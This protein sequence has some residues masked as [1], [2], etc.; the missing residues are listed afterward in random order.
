MSQKLFYVLEIIK[1][2]SEPI[3]AKEIQGKLAELGIIINIKTVYQLIKKA[4]EYYEHVL[5]REY[6]QTIRKKGYIINEDYFNDGQLQYL[7]DSIVFNKN[8]STKEIEDI[9][10][11]LLFYSSSNQINRINIP[12]ISKTNQPFSLLLNLTTL[13]RAINNQDL[14]Y[15]KYV[16]YKVNSDKL[17][18]VSSANGNLKIGEDI[19]YEVSP[20]QI[21]LNGSNYYLLG[22]FNKRKDQLSMYRV[23]RMRMIRKSN[24][25]FIDIREQFDINKEISNNVNM[26]ISTKKITLVFR[27]HDNIIREV[28]NQFGI[29]IEVK[30]EINNWNQAKVK[31][32]A[33]SEGL[34]GWIMMLQDQIEIILPT[35]LKSVIIDKICGLTKIYCI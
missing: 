22:Y 14:I 13:L 23:D 30:R 29:D 21:I 26:F 19:F 24:S 35:D 33:L 16:N 20:Y 2:S 31:N 4:N 15:F 10:K 34:I 12:A 6:I 27:F 5:K 25:K 1:A 17:V 8:L 3:T 11:Q 18:E 32:V 7:V 28:V 9:L